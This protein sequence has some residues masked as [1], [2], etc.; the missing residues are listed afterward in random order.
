MLTS[1]ALI[2]CNRIMQ[3]VAAVSGSTGSAQAVNEMVLATN[4]LLESFGNAK[5]IRN[6]NS[7]RFGK[8][9]EI[10]FDAQGNPVGCKVTSFLLEKNR[11]ATQGRDERNFHIFYQ[12]AKGATSE[13][14]DMLG[15]QGPEAYAYTNQCLNVPGIDDVADFKETVNAMNIIGLSAH[16]QS[17]IWRMIAAILWC[18][19]ITF[20]FDA[21]ENA[22]I[23][24]QSV[25]DFLAYLLEVN[26]DSIKKALTQRVMETQRGGRRGS[27]YEVPLNV[28]QASA[29][30]DALAKAIYNNLFEWII[31]RVNISMEAKSAAANAIGVLD[32]YGFE[33][34]E[35]N[36]FEQLCINFV[37]EKLQQIFIRLTLQQ[38]QQ[39][40]EDEG[41]KWTPINYFNN[42][43]VCDLIEERR[44]PGVFAA[45]NDACA[46]AHA[47]PAAADNSFVQR[48]GMLSSNLHFDSRGSK[49]LIKHYAG[50]VMYTVL[51]MT[52]KNKDALLKD[53]LNLVDSSQ[54]KFL[55]TLFPDRPDPDS[56][57]RPPTAGDRIKMS[58]NLLVDTLM[59]AQPS[60]IRCI[61]PNENKSSTE[62][63]ESACTHQVK[64][65]GLQENVRVRR[66]G[67]AYRNT[68]DRVVQRFYLLSPHTSYAGEY[69]WTADARSAC[70][71]I[72][73]DTK[74][75][76]E[77]WQLGITKAFIK[78]PETIFALE[79]MRDR[80]W[81]NMATRIQRAYRAYLRY[82]DESARR[83]QG[84]WMRE[85]KGL[86]YAQLRQYGHDVLAGRKE[87]RRYS[88][89]GSRR[90]FGDYLDVNG[91]SAEGEMLRSVAGISGNETVAFSSRVQL[92]VSRLG[93][94]S[95]PSPRFL[96]VTDRA[97]YFIV[98]QLVNKQV[99][100]VLERK[101]NVSSIQTVGLSCLRDDWVVFN[102]GGTEEPDPVFHCY[103]K[104]ELFVHLLQRS[105]G[106]INLRVDNT[107]QFRKKKDKMATITFKKDETV[108]MDDVYKSSTVSVAS[109]EAPTS[110]S[111]PAPRKKSGVMRPVTQGKLLRPGGPS[112]PRAAAR[113]VVSNRSTQPAKLPGIAATVAVTSAAASATPAVSSIPA[114]KHTSV[115][116]PVAPLPLRTAAPPTTQDK[117]MYKAL[118]DF[119]TTNE[120]EMALNSNE[121]VEVT[122]KDEGGGWWLVKKGGVEGWAPSTYLELVPPK[123]QLAPAVP[124]PAP[125]KRQP[126]APPAGATASSVGA[127]A[128]KFSGSSTPPIGGGAKQ[129]VATKPK[130]AMTTKTSERPTSVSADANA[131]PVAV[132]PGMATE[133]GL[134]AILA[135]KRA[136]R[137]AS[138]GGGS[139]GGAASARGTPPPVAPKPGQSNGKVPPPPLRR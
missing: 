22:L 71:R 122:Q 124:A 81:H 77:E 134:A 97:A 39:E 63:D 53:I 131:A 87:R 51:G 34:F 55:H 65:L 138:E 37:N 48:L 114:A 4:P 68:F 106:A 112:K 33:I 82:K 83:I 59:Q 89:L 121:L 38:E 40:Y 102:V 24:D 46:T 62:Y 91:Q 50:D 57:K 123:P 88:L 54:N 1:C 80:Y 116:T 20:D 70:E 127:A 101:I 108:Q 119:A 5:T 75:P 66:A 16:E 31:Q 28:A 30:R 98:T 49:F 67:F 126:P 32:I 42:K 118:Y 2:F 86:A 9:L 105:N 85:K 76:R 3:F 52:E 74:I 35:N 47:D 92:L 25:T 27:V 15:V 109:G 139:S 129:A 45:L 95:K 94:S 120:G 26:S 6:N 84:M 17:E 60:Y 78:A 96:V 14:R 18:G 100:T 13:Q 128:S 132:M 58:A 69:T 43:I 107:L 110:Q 23:A 73:T 125:F 72:L 99:Q 111:Q 29:V 90:F 104:T 8:Y 36:S 93:R 117:P 10:S 19:N 130:Q 7:S 61:K 79:T 12:L 11:V 115:A 41:I 113:P 133:G 21:E 136:E 137:E 56:K 135:K 44:P 64:Y 103:F